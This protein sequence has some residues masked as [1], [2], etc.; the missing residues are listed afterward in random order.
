[1]TKPSSKSSSANKASSKRRSCCSEGTLFVGKLSTTTP[2]LKG[3]SSKLT[4]TKTTLKPPK[5]PDLGQIPQHPISEVLF[6]R[7]QTNPSKRRKG[8]K[9]KNK[10]P[11]KN[12]TNPPKLSET[13]KFDSFFSQKL[14]FSVTL[15]VLCLFSC[16]FPKKIRKKKT[17]KKQRR[18]IKQEQGKSEIS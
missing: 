15:G 16:N 3:A 18:T 8:K 12:Q 17:K 2:S 5:P 11:Q 14:L 6:L 13:P 1:V 9:I 7:P 10:K 4:S